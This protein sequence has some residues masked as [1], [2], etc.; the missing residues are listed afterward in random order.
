MY[1][2][3]RWLEDE[4]LELSEAC[5]KLA[6]L[7][8]N[9]EWAREHKGEPVHLFHDHLVDGETPAMALALVKKVFYPINQDA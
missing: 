2:R 5:N 1:I 6:E 4:V 7:M 8:E 3:A 9:D